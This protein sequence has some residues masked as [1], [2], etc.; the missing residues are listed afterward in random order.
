M[1]GGVYRMLTL[2]KGYI[3]LNEDTFSSII[4]I[5]NNYTPIRNS[6]KVSLA[7]LT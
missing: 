6:Y 4:S 3:K 5:C 7:G 2:N 1:K